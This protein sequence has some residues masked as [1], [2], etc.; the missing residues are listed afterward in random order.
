VSLRPSS[1]RLRLTLWYSLV[2]A[3]TVLIL[4]LFV[5]FFVQ[6]GLYRQLNQQLDSDFQ[7]VSQDFSED[8]NEPLEIEAENSAKIVQIVKAG[9]LFYQTP[10]YHKAGLPLLTKIPAVGSRTVRSASGA[11][12]HLKTGLV[13]PDV[14]MTVALD[15]QPVRNTLRT[16]AVILILALPIALTLAA[17]GGFVMA[18]RLL[19]PIAVITA[20]AE[21][22]SAESLSERLPLENPRDEFGRLA[23][24]INVMLSRLED[25]FGRLKRFTADASHELR[26]PLTVIR[27]VGEVALQEDLDAGAYRDRIGS[28]LEEVDRLSRLVDSLLVLTR[29]D[30]GHVSLRRKETDLVRLVERAVED[31]RA[32]AEEKGQELRQALEGPAVL[33]I[34][35]ATVRLALVNLLDNAIKYTPPSGTITV[36]SKMRGEDFLVEITDTGH[37]IPAEHRDRIFD[38]FYRVDKDRTGSAGGAGLGLSIARWAVEANGGRIE[39]DSQENRGSKFRLVF[40]KDKPTI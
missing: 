6:A 22:I 35:E 2:L 13:A 16:L 27:S 1:V 32:L 31:M 21:K 8:P 17:F 34:D 19:R 7:A 28:M 9:V 29:V 38:R 39:L 40:P 37:G 14:L 11:R 12:F 36:R 4:S 18:G 26:T 30:S 33:R 25:A 24:V 23:G 5:F 15:E 3:G 20:R 10:A